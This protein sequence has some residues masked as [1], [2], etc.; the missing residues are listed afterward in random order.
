MREPERS[1]GPLQEERAGRSER[2]TRLCDHVE[3]VLEREPEFANVHEVR[4]DRGSVPKARLVKPAAFDLRGSHPRQRVIDSPLRF[5]C[6]RED[7][8][9]P[10][11]C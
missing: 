11:H 6:D 10:I 4:N 1:R 8:F 9:V 7:M 3:D 2:D 5:V